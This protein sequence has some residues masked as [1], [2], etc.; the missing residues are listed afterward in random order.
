MG[1][2]GEHVS[3]A[4]VLLVLPGVL[5]LADY[6]AFVVV[7]VDAPDHTGLNPPVHDL[8]IEKEPALPVPDEN[9]SGD[10][11]VQS[12]AGLGIHPRIVGVDVLREIDVRASDVEKAVRIAPSQLSCLPTIDYVVGHGGYIAGQLGRGTDREKGMESHR[13]L[14]LNSLKN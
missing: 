13:I 6:A 10:E 5:V 7:H 11:L 9:A 12:L 2:H 8:A 14:P 1:I 4:I 3:S